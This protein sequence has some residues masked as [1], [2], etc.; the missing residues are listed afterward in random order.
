MMPHYSQF[1]ARTERP[2][3]V[4]AALQ[5]MD[6]YLFP[7]SPAGVVICEKSS[8]ALDVRISIQVGKSISGRLGE[9]IAVLAIAGNDGT[10]FWFG[11]FEGGKARFQHNRLAGP[12]DFVAKPARP[13]DIDALCASF[14]ANTS[15]EE[16]YQLLTG[17]H[18]MRP[19]D[20]HA[21]L[22]HSL[23]LPSWSPGVGYSRIAA[24]TVPPEAGTPERPP[25]S[26]RELRPA[27]VFSNDSGGS[28]SLACFKQACQAAFGFLEQ[29]YGF[30]AE[31]GQLS[32]GQ[33]HYPQ[34][35]RNKWIIG[36]GNL[37]PG[38]KNPYVV[39]YRSRHLTVVIEGLSFGA[40]TRLCLIDRHG[41]QLDLTR[42]VE[43]RDPVL[44]DLCRLAAVQ[45]EQIPIFAEALRKCAADVLVGESGS[46]SPEADHKVGFT[47]SAFL[48]QADGDYVL[49]R[50]GP[51]FKP[52]TIAAQFRRAK[53]LLKIRIKILR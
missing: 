43:R 48:S 47:F 26:L 30:Q 33:Y 40:R 4:L 13:V 25:R 31:L 46:I 39:R 35:I 10:G 18:S 19:V 34:V 15:R 17:P 12:S 36:S 11:L 8:E 16:I 38:H 49:A 6:V 42:L 51:R 50:F 7:H 23:G 2:T 41:C 20:L 27:A 14:G 22:A 1:F 37:R 29:Q 32:L 28:D 21:G 44:L 3:Q 53:L 5:G 52:R 9:G 45:S 24:G